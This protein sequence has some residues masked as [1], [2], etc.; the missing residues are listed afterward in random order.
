MN[1]YLSPLFFLLFLAS[2][3]GCKSQESSIQNMYTPH[4]VKIFDDGN[5]LQGNEAIASHYKNNP[6]K[7]KTM[8]SDTL[9]LASKRRGL[10][11]EMGSFTDDKGNTFKQIII[12]KKTSDGR[13]RDFEIVSKKSEHRV[14]SEVI[15]QQRSKWME[16]CNAHDVEGLAN[17]IY[18][19]NNLYYN[20]KPLVI[21]RAQLIKEYQYMTNEQYSLKL[22]PILSEVV[23]ENTV[24]EI[25]QCAEGYNGKYII[26]WKKNEDGIWQ[27]LVDSNI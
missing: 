15:D 25:G 5:Y 4:A 3:M 8:S 24:F 1:T 6:I 11:Y 17:T 14:N 23:N 9:I 22:T 7:I 16:Y 26:V 21:G 27:V 18:T 13:K 12:W 19:S 10:E 2:A 20:H